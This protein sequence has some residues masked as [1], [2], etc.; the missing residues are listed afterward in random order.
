M[1]ITKDYYNFR[2]KLSLKNAYFRVIKIE[3]MF[4]D[5]TSPFLITLDVYPSDDAR[6]QKAEPIERM[7]LI[8]PSK[9]V[10]VFFSEDVLEIQGV[11]IKKAVYNYIKQLPEFSGAVDN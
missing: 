7:G 1:A 10:P 2:N 9:D 5:E 3:W 6:K 4:F 8:V 11:T